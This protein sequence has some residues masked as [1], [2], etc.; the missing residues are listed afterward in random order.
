MI[1]Y[2]KVF[3]TL[4]VL[5][6]CVACESG[7]ARE[8]ESL[9]S[10]PVEGAETAGAPAV[11]LYTDLGAH[12]Y[13]INTRVTEAQQYFDQGLRLTYA[14]NHAEATRAFEEAARLDPDCAI[15]HWGAA[16][17]HGP[18]INAPMDEAAGRDAYAALQRALALAPKASERERALIEA[19]VARYAEDAPAERAHLDSAYARAMAELHRR[20]PDDLE[21]ATLSAEALMDLRP[22]DYWRKDGT[23]YPGTLEAVAAL[24]R[25]IELNPNHPGACHYY[26]HAVEAVAPEKAVP[27]A[28]RL[29]ALMPGAGH[30]VHM[31]AHIYIRVGRW[32]DAITANEHA[33]HAD[34]SYIA[35]QRPQGVYPIAYYPHNY[36]F[37]S[38]AAAMIGDQRR[39]IEAARAV[40]AN[41]PVDVA[42]QVPPVEPLVAYLH[43]T[44][45]TFGRWDELLREPVPP[46]DLRFASG[47]VQYARGVAF[48]AQQRWPDAARALERVRSSNAA[49]EAGGNK[50]LLEI[51]VHA[52]QGEIAL[53]RD[54]LPEAEAHFRQ[55][56]TLEDGILYFEPPLWYYPIRHSLGAV[57]LRA[58]RAAEAER[59]YR[60][61]LRRFPENGWALFGLAQS[62]EA[63]ARTAEAAEARRRFEQVWAAPEVR[64]AASRF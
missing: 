49:M 9:A 35:D 15:C 37:L 11:P 53:R 21:I 45:A 42:R 12:H 38:F 51:A 57:L 30:L 20:Y 32:A 33:V 36:H 7:G 2:R 41:V 10:R 59:V 8:G 47:M 14:F 31:P 3:P 52:L 24:E 17:A 43:L 27:C 25:V 23:P 28:E 50:T 40:V 1:T 55:A 44:L 63:Q 6:L 16:Y 5:L 64:L 34:E 60:E 61:D 29:A 62:L 58:G 46:E 13:P 4:A 26:I 22:W 54:V 39:A 48:A 18:N 56:V 19:L